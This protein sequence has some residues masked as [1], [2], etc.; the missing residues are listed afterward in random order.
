MN[1]AELLADLSSKTITLIGN[2]SLKATAG[3]VKTYIQSVLSSEGVDKASDRNIA[4]VVVDEGES[5]EAAYY[6]D[7][8]AM[9]KNDNEA[10]LSYLASLVAAG[11]IDGFDVGKIRS[12]L[13]AFSYFIADVWM[14]DGAGKLNE[15]QIR[16]SYDAQGAATHKEII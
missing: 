6:R 13:G 1:K 8:I 10:G 11:T 9:P 5:T 16:V 2:E 4:F 3:S 14:D 15:K 7:T 12:D